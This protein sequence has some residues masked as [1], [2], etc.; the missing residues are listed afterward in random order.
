[1]LTGRYT[2]VWGKT[3]AYPRLLFSNGMLRQY[4]FFLGVGVRRGKGREGPYM[5]NTNINML[6]YSNEPLSLAL[7]LYIDK[8]S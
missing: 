3:H 7:I 6:P 1:M 2:C 4:N 5:K 8:A